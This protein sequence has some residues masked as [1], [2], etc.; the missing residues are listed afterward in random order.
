MFVRAHARRHGDPHRSP[1]TSNGHQNVD[2][3]RERRHGHPRAT[4]TAATSR[5]ARP[6]ARPTTASPR[7]PR[8][9]RPATTR[10]T[11][12]TTCR[13]RSA[14]A[15]PASATDNTYRTPTYLHRPAASWPPQTGPDGA[16]VRH[17]YT[18]G[19]EAAV[20]GGTCPPGLVQTTT[21][22]RGAVTR[23]GYY[24][25]GDLRP[26][27]RAVRAASPTFTYDALGRRITET[28]DLR[29]LP[30]RVSPRPTPTTSCPGWSP[31]TA[32]VTT[33]ARRRHQA[34]E[35]DDQQLRR[36]RQ[37]R[38][39]PRS[40]DA[41]TA[42]AR[43]GRRPSS[44][45]ST[46]AWSS[47][48]DAEGN[49]TTYG[50]DQFGNRTS[51]VDANGNRYEYAYTA[52]NKIAEVRLRDWHSDPAGAGDPATGDYIVL[53]LVRLR[54]RRPDGCARPTRWAAR[55]EYQYY[56][57][58]P[59]CGRS[60]LKDFR[61]PD[62]TKRDYVVEENTYDGAGNL[63]RQVERQRPRSSPSTRSTGPARSRRPRSDPAGSTATHRLHLR[64]G[65][66]RHHAPAPPATAA[67]CPWSMPATA[68]DRRI[69]LRRGRQPRPG[70]GRRR[71]APTRVTSYTLRP[72]R[73]GAPPRPTRAATSRGPTSRGLHHDAT[74]YDE[75]RPAGRRRPRRAVAAE[76]DGGAPQQVT[77]D[78]DRS[79]T[80]RSAR[81]WPAATPLGNVSRRTYDRLGR[82]VTRQRTGLHTG[83]RRSP[84][85]T[86]HRDHATTR[87][88]T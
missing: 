47:T 46:T 26:G 56:R 48:T 51:M 81:P 39:A 2:H 42:D 24:A 6:A 66:Q 84:A 11:R 72:A 67:T 55:L 16:G 83:R 88:A 10:S 87:S 20:G 13:S 85:I 38:P 65:R 31:S 74:R 62:G 30:G 50:Y 37:R 45:T 8:T 12:A 14:T 17:T 41:L 22:P 60:S 82:A 71:R 25:N 68:A 29:R 73:P 7:T 40:S 28:G 36:R 49:E 54:L 44:T 33:D 80:T 63:T 35:R 3:Q 76:S 69:R 34:P 61:N 32:P 15:G 58:R 9:R 78:R 70:E 86:D 77:P 64:P 5:P 53:Q 52:R 23:Y 4:T 18:T 79:A 21:D 19:G 43:A 27:D 1:T 75:T 59:A 57:R